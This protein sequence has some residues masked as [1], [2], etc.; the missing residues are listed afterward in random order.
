[1][2]IGMPAVSAQSI[3]EPDPTAEFKQGVKL[4]KGGY[5]KKALVHFRRAFECQKENPYYLSFLGLSIA[6][7][8]RKWEQASE[9]CEIAVQLRRKELQFHLNLADVYAA[10]GR[11]EKALDTLDTARELF[12]DDERLM[13]ARSHVEKR[14]SP[15]LA[16]LNREHYLN[17]ELGKLRHRALKHLGKEK[18]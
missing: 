5:A 12:G 8:Q 7:A 6:H 2:N 1:M 9:L 3:P 15:V 4:L 10:A 14:R 17:R 13:R 11:R 16:F 18:G